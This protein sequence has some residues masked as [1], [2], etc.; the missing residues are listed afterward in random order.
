MA[1]EAETIADLAAKSVGPRVITNS[2]GREFIVF[3]DGSY[4]DI[5]EPR[6][7]PELAGDRI[8][9]TVT[10]DTEA[11]FIAYVNRYKDANSTV[12]GSVSTSTI[13]AALDYHA[14]TDG[15]LG[16]PRFTDHAATLKLRHSLEW[17]TWTSVSGRLMSQIEFARF[18][19]EHAADIT[20]PRGADLLEMCRDIQAVRKAEFSKVVRTASGTERFSYS[21]ETKA[22]SGDIEVPTQLS[23][24]LPVYFGGTTHSMKAFLRWS[25]K[26][27]EL[28]LGVQLH[29]P[30]LIEQTAFDEVLDRIDAKT[31]LQTLHGSAPLRAR[32]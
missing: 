22:T 25:L 28:S 3:P 31:G 14:S 10:I 13:V 19:E 32:S 18:I 12:F 24:Y 6:S 1:N 16:A 7:I 27:G 20:S 8:R 4:H 15:A 5:S 11:S 21:E 2:A 17:K 29:Q 23:L 26:E 9:Q 30:E